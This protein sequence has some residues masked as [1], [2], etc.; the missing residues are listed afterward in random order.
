MLNGNHSACKI[1]PKSYVNQKQFANTK[2]K[3]NAAFRFI[4]KQ[5]D[6][7]QRRDCVLA[8][9]LHET[10]FGKNCRRVKDKKEIEIKQ[11]L[12]RMSK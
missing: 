11:T 5:F 12:E 4:L 1:I 7:A 3:I 10:Q 2:E 8:E 6:E 9:A